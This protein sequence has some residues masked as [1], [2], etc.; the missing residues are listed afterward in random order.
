M[1]VGLVKNFLFI[2]NIFIVIVKKSNIKK[3]QIF[4]K[5]LHIRNIDKLFFI[6]YNTEK[7][8]NWLWL[9]I[10]ISYGKS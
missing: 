5:V 7:K 8:D 6:G 4:I 10:I 2:T 1:R 9:F 3:L